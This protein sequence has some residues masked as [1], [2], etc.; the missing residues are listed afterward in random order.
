MEINFKLKEFTNFL[1]EE[2]A[3]SPAEVAV[4][5]ERRQSISDPLPMLLWQYGLVSIE[6]LQRIFDWLDNQPVCN[7]LV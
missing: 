3:I 5:I 2:L 6:Q 4:V 1:Q 7:V